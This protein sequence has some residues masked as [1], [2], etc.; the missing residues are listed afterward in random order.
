MKFISFFKENTIIKD[1]IA[2]LKYY[3]IFGIICMFFSSVS[4]IALP[5]FIGILIDFSENSSSSQ[6]I[7]DSNNL[8]IFIFIALLIS[9]IFQVS[10][11][12][13]FFLFAEKSVISM[14][15]TLYS[16]LVRFPISFYDKNLKG[17]LF[18]RINT[19]IS[20]IKNIFSQQVS[21]LLY[22]PF[23]ISIC[24]INIFRINVLL[25]I[26]LVSTIPIVTYISLRLGDK[27]K[28]ISKETLDLYASSNVLL[29]ETLTLIKT[30]K[31]FNKESYQED[32]YSSSTNQV[33]SKSIHL[34]VTRIILQVVAS[35]LLLVNII[36][37]FW[38][39]SKL[40]FENKIT[41][42][43]LLEYITNTFFIGSSISSMASAYGIIKKSSGAFSSLKKL[44]DEPTELID[45]M[46]I[47]NEGIK[48]TESIVF[49]KVSFCYPT[50]KE[51][52]VF[53]DL[54][55]SINKGDKIGFIGSSGQGKSTLLN[56]LLRF[57]NTNNG[58]ITID[59]KNINSISL[60]QYRNIFTV[61]SQE[62]VLFSGSVLDN[63]SYGKSNVSF[64]DIVRACEMSN[65]LEF[66]SKLPNK[67]DT[68]VGDNGVSLSGGQRQR[69]AIARAILKDP[70]I[71]VFDE[72]TSALDRES[73][74]IINQSILNSLRGKTI[75]VFSHKLSIMQEMD[76][77]YEIRNGTLIEIKTSEILNLV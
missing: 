52:I 64:K 4:K 35:S 15:Q 66:I 8:I 63:I 55:V 9:T 7:K 11:N 26:I 31:I 61:V 25:S 45:K 71:F 32:K 54:D 76:K 46:H 36:V 30:I 75:I 34:A 50:R 70:E 5:H 47:S 77:V 53:K 23:I 24:I 14:M 12:Y 28:K 48:F 72:A 49:D 18:S 67:F 33:L 17:D 19:E 62:I 56:L 41:I 6:I 10:K 65:A 60:S 51:N 40:M 27:V 13:F 1:I 16:R 42:G 68:Q 38:L 22:H 2:P 21:S 74:S 37:I 58:L 39:A 69:I 20:T 59:N 3:L 43:Q 73:E 44:F 57:Y 29:E